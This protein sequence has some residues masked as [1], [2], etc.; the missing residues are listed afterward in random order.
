MV[1]ETLI[2][3]IAEAIYKQHR[4]YKLTSRSVDFYLLPDND[5]TIYLSLAH[6]II[7][8]FDDYYDAEL[9]DDD[10]DSDMLDDYDSLDDDYEDHLDY[11]EL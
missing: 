9:E 8:I 10:D 4:D 11:M 2:D 3:L 6:D 1:D 5:K 7:G